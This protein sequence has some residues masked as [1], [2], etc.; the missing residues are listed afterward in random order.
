MEMHL[1]GAKCLALAGWAGRTMSTSRELL[2]LAHTSIADTFEWSKN[3]AITLA[4]WAIE[5]LAK[6][7]AR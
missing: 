4:R 6:R 5:P 1:R 3:A 2:S 7:E